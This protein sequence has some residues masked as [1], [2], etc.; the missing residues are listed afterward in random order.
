MWSEA[1]IGGL[2]CREV[3]DLCR[4]LATGA[5]FAL[6]S[7]EA[8]RTSD[9]APLAQWVRDQ[10]PWSDFPF[11]PLTER[12]GMERN[13]AASRMVAA[14][15][16]V[17]F[18][19]RPF[20]PTSLVSVARTALRARQRQYDARQLIEEI[21]EA[22]ALLERR[23]RERRDLLQSTMGGVASIETVL[24]P[25]LWPATIDPTQIELVILNL[26]INGRDAMEGGGSPVVKTANTLLG[27]PQYPEE[28]PAGDYVMVSV[29]DSG[30]GMTPEVRAK[31]FEP[32][33]T[34]KPVGRGSGLGL[35]Q[36]Y[37]L[38]KQSGGGV[39]IIT[40]PGKGTSVQVFLP[41]AARAC[42]WCSSPATPTPKAWSAPIPT[43]S[44]ASRSTRAS[45]PLSSAAP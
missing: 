33:F 44:C 41:R 2:A 30:T 9:L 11:I 36:V 31:A 23:V 14:L 3:D 28:P 7:D 16:N 39:R 20:H 21:R 22:E 12:G 34:T 5:G 4:A 1:G 35:S 24:Q 15:G 13:P 32:F 26:A 18:L 29:T 6:V 17:V 19:E 25:D 27:A 38:A 8:R 40:G 10:P 42:P 37:G 43:R 45:F